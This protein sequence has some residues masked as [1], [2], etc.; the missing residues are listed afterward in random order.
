VADALRIRKLAGI[1]PD[2]LTRVFNE[3]FA[4]YVIPFVAT[5]EFKDFR[6]ALARVDW[7]LS[8]GA[9]DGDRL[10]G[11]CYHGVDE[12]EG[13]RR[14]YNAGTGVLPAYRGQRLVD[15]IYED[16]LPLFQER[17]VRDCTL[18]VIAGNDRAVRVY[19]RIGFQVRR[20]LTYM[21]GELDLPRLKEKAGEVE[22]R[23]LD[24]APWE[25]LQALQETLPAWDFMLSAAKVQGDGVRIVGAYD[26][27]QLVGASILRDVDHTLCWLSVGEEHRR[28]GVASALLL[29]A[30]QQQSEWRM[31]N[32]DRG[33]RHM[34][35][36]L[37]WAGLREEMF[38]YEMALDCSSRTS[39]DGVC[40]RP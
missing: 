35:A 27:D 11:F 36:F 15:R 31:V 40:R 33:A 6:W 22:L 39:V 17:G 19:E 3:A 20:E 4:D 13:E 26:G 14:A 30:I 29:P 34:M 9:F 28:R 23:E 5:R 2:D 18:E 25:A 24:Q 21:K 16:T 37:S 10:V 12:V 38:Q 7:E 8:L 1:H 32:V